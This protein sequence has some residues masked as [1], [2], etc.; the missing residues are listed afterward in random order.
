MSQS[1]TAMAP[2]FI[3]NTF[4]DGVEIMDT[5]EGDAVCTDFKHPDR[6]Q[7][8]EHDSLLA[9]WSAR[10]F[11]HPLYI[12]QTYGRKSRF[13][14]P[15]LS[16]L[17]ENL[18]ITLPN[19]ED[20]DSSPYLPIFTSR[21]QQLIAELGPHLF[22]SL[23]FN[24]VLADNLRN[25]QRLLNLSEMD[26]RIL[27]FLCLLN[28]SKRFNEMAE[29]L[30]DMTRRDLTTMLSCLLSASDTQIDKAL[31]KHG[32]LLQTGLIRVNT[33]HNSSLEYK[34]E[35]L[36]GLADSLFQTNS[37]P[38][39]M[40][41]GF[42]TASRPAELTLAD[43]PH[44]QEDSE[45]L[46]AYIQTKQ[47]TVQ[48]DA[49]S[50]AP[51]AINILVYGEPGTGKT[52]WVKA[53]ADHLAMT[54]YDISSEDRDGEAMAKVER[55][56]AYRLAQAALAQQGQSVI[57][58]DEVE[59]AFNGSSE[60]LTRGRRVHSNKAWMNTLLETNPVPAF[61]LTNDIRQID[62][63]FIR[64]FD[65]VIAMPVP[66]K[67]V[68]LALLKRLCAPLNLRDSWLNALAEQRTLVPAVIERAVSVLAT[69]HAKPVPAETVEPLLLNRINQTLKAQQKKPLTLKHQPDAITYS[70]DYIHCD[71]DLAELVAGIAQAK[72]ARLC[73]YG[74]PGT[75]KSAFGHYL[76]H[77][78]DQPLM[79]KRA[80]D[81]I[82]AYVGETEQNL[83]AAFEQAREEG[84]VLQIDEADSF[85]HSRDNAQRSWEVTKINELLTQLES[86]E[87]VFIAST[88]R[89]DDLDAAAM[90]RFDLK[91]E[92]K[93]LKAEQAWSL[94]NDLF[95]DKPEYD[96]ASE[97]YAD[98][99]Q[100]LSQLNQLTPGDFAVVQRQSRLGLQ[101][102]TPEKA[103]AVLQ[104]ECRHKPGYSPIK[105]MGFLS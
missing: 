63:A 58:F 28:Y 32:K 100:Q 56:G 48:D 68:R 71:A 54:L 40:L 92:F 35:L 104:A 51:S 23:G 93:S 39:V 102:L 26:I 96:L 77:T 13:G 57:L 36:A 25:L 59:D 66:P 83:A 20:E 3:L 98:I 90:R 94:F 60:L 6:L 79:V 49:S 86:F 64:R 67:A 76:A 72:Q 103:L 75:G 17:S 10:I 91:L 105:G 19:V 14:Q 97:T 87:G 37:D 29:G 82:S 101:K 12:R 85:L 15:D 74:L 62:P 1:H 45:T 70:L 2:D 84:A 31:G 73:L 9:L 7:S 16:L 89:M 99:K 34:A 55:L 46:A 81:L 21:A 8:S 38:L 43:F 80:S 30:G 53:L 44:L 88:N 42:F 24:G 33:E 52:Q 4:D 95:K 18:G 78:L 41:D 69:T 22:K 27:G 11:L 5:F 50:A 65:R 47:A 61:W